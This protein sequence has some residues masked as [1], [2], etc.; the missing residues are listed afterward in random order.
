VVALNTTH[1]LILFSLFC[2][3]NTTRYQK[4]YA[5]GVIRS[6]QWHSPPR[7]ELAFD[8]A[9]LCLDTG[10]TVQTLERWETSDTKVWIALKLK[11]DRMPVKSNGKAQGITQWVQMSRPYAGLLYIPN[12]MDQKQSRCYVVIRSYTI[13]CANENILKMQ[14]KMQSG[15]CRKSQTI[16]CR[17]WRAPPQRLEKKRTACCACRR[18]A[19]ITSA[20]VFLCRWRCCSK[21]TGFAEIGLLMELILHGNNHWIT[22]ANINNTV[23]RWQCAS[24]SATVVIHCMETV[25]FVKCRKCRDFAKMLCFLSKCHSFMIS[26][27]YFVFSQHN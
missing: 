15:I 23:I 10:V 19:S 16:F 25:I 1:Y 22:V 14:V 7:N 5:A 4:A 6:P 3:H 20:D 24:L 27:E 21:A 12:H 26:Q 8:A 18:S 17:G 13:I 2:R 9:L 11:S